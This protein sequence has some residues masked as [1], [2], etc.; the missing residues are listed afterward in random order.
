MYFKVDKPIFHQE[1]VRSK[2]EAK[3]TFVLLSNVLYSMPRP[4]LGLIPFNNSYGITEL[5]GFG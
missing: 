5:L 2:L 3:R 1:P 4:I